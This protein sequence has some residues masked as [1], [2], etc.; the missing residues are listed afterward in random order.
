MI[1]YDNF[2]Q[3]VN[4]CG[5]KTRVCEF[6]HKNVMMRNQK[7]HEQEEC[8]RFIR[9]E[10]EKMEQEKIKKLEEEEKR[11][12]RLDEMKK[13]RRKAKEDKEKAKAK[14][15]EP[16]KPTGAS[17]VTR[18]KPTGTG[19][20]LPDYFGAPKTKPSG[21]AGR[22]R[23]KQPT[24]AS[25]PSS[26]YKPSDRS[27]RVKASSKEEEKEPSSMYRNKRRNVNK[28]NKNVGS[29]DV[30]MQDANLVDEIPAEV[31]NQIYSEDL[32]QNEVEQL[33]SQEYESQ[34]YES[35]EQKYNPPPPSNDQ[36]QRL[37]GGDHP[38]QDDYR[39]PPR[40]EP[41]VRDFSP[42][43]PS[44]QNP[45]GMGEPPAENENDLIQKAIAA[46]LQ[47]NN[48]RLNPMGKF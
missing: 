40:V 35:Q 1:D 30:P 15:T 48:P 10:Y 32:D 12:E 46:S 24:E 13:A 27:R 20:A 37:I 25:K 9:E 29:Q 2:L 3:H 8:A 47:D 5:A 28:D 45:G 31:L 14:P 39:R 11:K 16:P 4:F 26:Y 42:P 17:R 44:E 7:Y 33:Q 19:R 38:M 34:G 18:S 36:P 41:R 23:A 22:T 21:I 6:C 43:V